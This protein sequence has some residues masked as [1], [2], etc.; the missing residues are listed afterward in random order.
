MRYTGVDGFNGGASLNSPEI[1]STGIQCN[2]KELEQLWNA[3]LPLK[4]SIKESGGER[5]E[6]VAIINT[7]KNREIERAIFVTLRKD[8][9]KGSSWYFNV[10]TNPASVFTGDNTFGS[11]RVIAKVREVFHYVLDYFGK[12]GVDVTR[13]KKN[14]Q[15]GEISVHSV[16]FASYTNLL[17]NEGLLNALID[18]WFFMYETR[19]LID[20]SYISLLEELGLSR[21]NGEQYQ[22][23]ISL[24]VFAEGRAGRDIQNRGNKL[25]HLCVYNK[26]EELREKEKLDEDNAELIDDLSR[27]ARF[28][29]T[30]TNYFFNSQWGIKKV[31]LRSLY[32]YVKEHWGDRMWEGAVEDLMKYAVR[33]TCLQYMM[34][35]P[36]PFLAEHKNMVTLWEQQLQEKR[37]TKG[38]WKWDLKLKKWSDTLGMNLSVSPDAHRIMLLGQVGLHTNTKTNVNTWLSSSKGTKSYLSTLETELNRTRESKVLGKVAASLKLD[39]SRPTYMGQQK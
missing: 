7:A 28:D 30:I 5:K 12:R 22:T 31:T 36:N 38:R 32:D 29:L 1:E 23:S 34:N 6:L 19:M 8:A 35:V 25:M 14:V 3:M 11:L 15:K 33:R 27:R 10:R 26:I 39:F 2:T 9:R 20:K 13:L 18:R 24:N 4:V 16:T 37:N 21:S 17:A